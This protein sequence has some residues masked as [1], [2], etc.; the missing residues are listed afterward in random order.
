MRPAASSSQLECLMSTRVLETWPYYSRQ[1]CRNNSGTSRP[2]AAW[3]SLFCRTTVIEPRDQVAGRRWRSFREVLYCIDR[4]GMAVIRN[5]NKTSPAFLA[6]GKSWF[7]KLRVAY[8]NKLDFESA[9]CP[10]RNSSARTTY[11]WNAAR[12]FVN[13]IFRSALRESS[14]YHL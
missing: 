1:I 14:E 13:P 12:N 9:S 3:K 2:W 5:K 8:E 10:P 7:E 11:L 4:T 6:N